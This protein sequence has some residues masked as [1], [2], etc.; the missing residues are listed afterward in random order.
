MIKYSL[1]NKKEI[2]WFLF[3]SLFS[4]LFSYFMIC[5]PNPINCIITYYIFFPNFFKA[6]LITIFHTYF[7]SKYY[8]MQHYYFINLKNNYLAPKLKYYNLDNKKAFYFLSDVIKYFKKNKTR[9]SLS[10]FLLLLFFS[11]N[12]ILFVNRIRIWIYFRKK[13]KPYQFLHQKIQ[14][15]T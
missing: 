1:M 3:V 4:Y 6:I 11:I 8:I 10:L 9:L 13:E 15:F 14:L 2:S 7:F 12:I 5:D